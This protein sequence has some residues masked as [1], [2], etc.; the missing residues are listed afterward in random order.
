MYQFNTFKHLEEKWASGLPPELEFRVSAQV[1]YAS[2]ASRMADIFLPGAL[3]MA[4][5][6]LGGGAPGKYP[7]LPSGSAGD[8]AFGLDWRCYPRSS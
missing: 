2:T 8:S 7:G 3:R 6:L 1:R 5:H 4:A